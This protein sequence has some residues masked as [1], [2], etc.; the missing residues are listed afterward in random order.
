[1][2]GTF[3]SGDFWVGANTASN[4]AHITGGGTSL[5]P[6]NIIVGAGAGGAFNELYVSDGAILESGGGTIG[7]S[8]AA[9]ANT[10]SLSGIGTEWRAKLMAVGGSSNAENRLLV[11]NGA[12]MF[13][14]GI[15][16]GY[17]TGGATLLFWRASGHRSY[18]QVRFFW[19]GTVR[20]T[21]S[22]SNVVP[23]CAVIRVTL[24][25][26]SM[27]FQIVSEFQVLGRVGATV[28]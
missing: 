17:M 5:R 16:V 12:A 23:A 28:C 19:D 11:R 22:A 20:E 18:R 6:R 26:Y 1:M 14:G 8:T 3:E 15:Q 13:A 9:N 24:G 21:R 25:N 10:A 2:R 4:V 27:E 7:G